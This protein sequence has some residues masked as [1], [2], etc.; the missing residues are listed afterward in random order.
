MARTTTEHTIVVQSAQPTGVVREEAVGSGSII[1]GELLEYRSGYVQRV[2]TAGV[3]TPKFVAL[4]NQT[5]NTNTYPTTASIDVPYTSGDIVYFAQAQAGDIY[6]MRLDSA[7]GTTT[8]G[9]DWLIT[10]A[11]GQ[12]TS[13]GT[14]I[15]VGTS[16]AIGI[17][18]ETV[19]VGGTATRCL[20]RIV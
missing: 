10:T 7:V 9:L 1:P 18:W 20:V 12:L 13:C 16:N 4:E 17:A 14:G 8:I 15:S 2:S 6:N 19:A 3:A 11:A 5:I